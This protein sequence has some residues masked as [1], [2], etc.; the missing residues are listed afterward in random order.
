MRRGCGRLA[1]IG[2]M[3]LSGPLLAT[4]LPVRCD[5]P[6]NG[7]LRLDGRSALLVELPEHPERLTVEVWVRG[8]PPRGRQGLLCNTDESGFAIFWSDAADGEALPMGFVHTGGD[9]RDERD[10]PNGGGYAAVGADRPWDFARWTHL[11]L[12]YDGQK[13][14]FFVNGRLT[15]E[16]ATSGPVTPNGLPLVIGADVDRSVESRGRNDGSGGAVSFWKGDLDEVRVSRTGRYTADFT[17]ARRLEQ[18]ADTVLLL[19]F[20]GPLEAELAEGAVG[21]PRVV[22]FDSE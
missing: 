5:E 14:R 13:V 21:S 20:D 3:A 18:D 16:T 11:A 4:E 22:G 8:T 9:G 6:L 10:G 12:S 2:M 17:P 19:N 7:F 1:L 15:G